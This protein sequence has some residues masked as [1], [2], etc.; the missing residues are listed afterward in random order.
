MI[1]ETW[2]FRNVNGAFRRN[3]H[4]GLD[5]VFGPIALARGDI[6]R[7]RIA[8]Q[9]R[10]SNVVRAADAAFQHSAAPYGNVFR[11]AVRLNLASARM[12]AHTAELNIDNARSTEFNGGLRIAQMPNGLVKTQRGLQLLLQFGVNKCRPTRAAVPASTNENYPRG[13][14]GETRPDE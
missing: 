7:Q 1:A 12:A 9:G 3:L 14:S 10:N 5:H 8:G 6:S 2:S 11:E 4:F 13:S